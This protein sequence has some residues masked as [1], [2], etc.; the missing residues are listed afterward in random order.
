MSDTAGDTKPDHTEA[1]TAVPRVSPAPS[2]GDVLRGM[3]IGRLSAAGGPLAGLVVLCVV[4]AFSSQYFLTYR[5]E[6]NIIDQVAVIGVMAVGQTLVI[7][8]GGIDLSVAAVLTLSAMVMAWTYKTEGLPLWTAIL[9]ALAVGAGVGYVNGLLITYGKLQPFIATLG[10]LSVTTG[11]ALMVT[12]AQTINGFPNWF[13]NITT[14]TVAGIQIELLILI[15]IFGVVAF[16]LRYRPGGRAL[17]AIGGAEEV[18]RLSGIAVRRSK[19]LAYTMSGLSGAIGGIIVTS[20]LNS[21]QPVASTTDLLSVI[22]AVVIGGATLTGGAGSMTQTA[23]GMLIIGTVNDGL[24]LLNVSSN[25][26]QVILGLVI[27]AAVMSDQLKGK[28]QLSRLLPGKRSS[29]SSGSRTG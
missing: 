19:I 17:Y 13:L 22:A 26:Q 1:N 9:A 15:I 23:V 3:L 29:V 18:A 28:V 25:V 11:L 20:R 21:A 7:I 5:N 2:R 6:A 24:A 12:N 10:T 4:L 8:T 27:I 14:G 16:Y